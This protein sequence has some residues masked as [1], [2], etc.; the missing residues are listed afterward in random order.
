M[1]QRFSGSMLAVIAA[2]GVVISGPINRTVAQAPAPP[3]TRQ[4]RR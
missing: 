2:S 1:R 4:P 3:V